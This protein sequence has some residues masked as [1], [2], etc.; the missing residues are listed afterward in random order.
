MR[1]IRDKKSNLKL[2]YLSGKVLREKEVQD[3]LGNIDEDGKMTCSKESDFAPLNQVFVNTS[4]LNT[5][6]GIPLVKQIT[7]K[8]GGITVQV[9][10]KAV[11]LIKAERKYC[12][13]SKY[14]RMLH[15]L[16]IQ[17]QQRI[18]KEDLCRLFKVPPS[19]ARKESTLTNKVLNPAL[20]DMRRV[21]PNLV[22]EKERSGQ[23]V[24]GYF[25][26]KEDSA[27][28]TRTST[29]AASSQKQP[30]N[31]TDQSEGQTGLSDSSTSSQTSSPQSQSEKEVPIHQEQ[32]TSSSHPAENQSMPVH[33]NSTAS[34]A[35]PQEQPFIEAQE[36]FRPPEQKV[37]QNM[38][39]PVNSTQPVEQ[40]ADQNWQQTPVYNSPAASGKMQPDAQIYQ[41]TVE[42]A[43]QNKEVWIRSNN[44]PRGGPYPPVEQIYSEIQCSIEEAWI[45]LEAITT[46]PPPIYNWRGFAR[47]VVNSWRKEWNK[48]ADRELRNQEDPEQFEEDF[49]L[50]EEEYIPF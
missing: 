1:P 8:E 30:A 48:Q 18:S 20:K 31:Q 25:F 17:G 11:P 23:T 45:V 38:S 10:E 42:T 50:Y 44:I 46:T 26:Y 40:P 29:S 3:L 9:H 34:P 24:F 32:N 41:Q 16:L 5:N 35:E 49:E 13:T 43:G 7:R 4:T 47:D 37:D 19:C 12:F 6:K 27:S 2:N 14:G 21:S 22:M 28:K 36:D 15:S 39:Y 33:S